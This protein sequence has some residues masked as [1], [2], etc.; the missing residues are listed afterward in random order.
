[1]I[2][3]PTGGRCI[4]VERASELP[5]AAAHVAREVRNQYVLAFSPGDLAADGKH[6]HVQVKLVGRRDVHLFWRSGYYAPER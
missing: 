1:M 2:A 4:T 5:E 6:H 3:E